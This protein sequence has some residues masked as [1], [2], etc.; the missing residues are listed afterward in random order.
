MHTQPRHIQPQA[1]AADA[2]DKLEQ[3]RITTLLV[4]GG[5]DLKLVG[6]LHIGD[7]MRAKVI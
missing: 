4:C 1:L 5:D 3:H 7:L 6:A 2:A